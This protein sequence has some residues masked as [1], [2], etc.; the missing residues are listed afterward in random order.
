MANAML[1]GVLMLIPFVILGIVNSS[2]GGGGVAE[3]GQCAKD[4]KACKEFLT[5][6]KKDEWVEGAW[7]IVAFLV[8]LLMVSIVCGLGWYNRA[9]LRHKFGLPGNHCTDCV[10]W[11]FCQTCA[12]CQETRTLMENNVENGVW[13]G[14]DVVLMPKSAEATV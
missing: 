7:G 2:G 9:M 12:L 14:P 1:W 13:Y 10:L 11:W 5:S 8:V 6:M 4:P 3:S